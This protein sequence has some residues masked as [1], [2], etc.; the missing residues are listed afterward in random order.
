MTRAMSKSDDL[1]TEPTRRLLALHLAS[2]PHGSV[3]A[4]DLSGLTAPGSRD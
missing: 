2:M 1:T 3:F 4:L